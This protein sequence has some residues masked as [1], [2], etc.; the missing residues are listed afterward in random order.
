MEPDNL[1]YFSTRYNL[2]KLCSA[3]IGAS[4]LVIIPVLRAC[5]GD[6]TNQVSGFDFI[7]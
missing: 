3:Q 1:Y 2:S 5:T 7:M 4:I 6:Q